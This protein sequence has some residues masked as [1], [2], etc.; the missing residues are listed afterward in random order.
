[1]RDLAFGGADRGQREVIDEL[2][3]VLAI[4][5][6]LDC[7]S[8]AGADASPDV[9]QLLGLSVRSL[10]KSAVVTHRLFDGIPG[11]ELEAVVGVDE[12]LVWERKICDGHA[13][14]HRVHRQLLQRRQRH[15]LLLEALLSQL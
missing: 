11:D 12:W 6:Q 4:I 9:C 2:F 7:A 10:Q 13:L 1:M 3:P 15:W 14:L 8:L 5:F